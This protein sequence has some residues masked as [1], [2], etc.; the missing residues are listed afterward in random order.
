MATALK[1]TF[2]IILHENIYGGNSHRDVSNEFPQQ[3]FPLKM[4]EQRP[5]IR[6]ILVLRGRAL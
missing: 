5:F 2:V 6:V 1:V 4:R 3:T